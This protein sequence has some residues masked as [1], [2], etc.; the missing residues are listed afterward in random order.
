MRT[1]LTLDDDVAAQL[2]SVRRARGS[3]LKAVVNDALREGLTR[4]ANPPRQGRQSF[5]R[6]V[7]LGSPTLPDVDDVAE[8]LA[9][10]EGDAFR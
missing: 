4:L 2:E 1:T 3:T 10:V 7:S 6:P 9:R 8:V 5:T